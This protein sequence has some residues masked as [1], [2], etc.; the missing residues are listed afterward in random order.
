D[1]LTRRD[2][3]EARLKIGHV[4]ALKG[5]RL[6]ALANYQQALE[7]LDTLS[8]AM[9]AHAG[10]RLLL[11]DA[12]ARVG[13]L[14]VAMVSVPRMTRTKRIEHLRAARAAYQRSLDITIDMQS[15]GRLS[16]GSRDALSGSPQDLAAEITKCEAALDAQGV[17]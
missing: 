2:L 7:I 4:L 17:H 11:A 8:S 9:P 12:Y 10:I 16:P 15:S 14:N 3:A 13:R 5:E 6:E 1:K